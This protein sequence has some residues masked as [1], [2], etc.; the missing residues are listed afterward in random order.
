MRH[1]RKRNSH[2]VGIGRQNDAT[3]TAAKII[4]DEGIDKE[5][6]EAFTIAAANGQDDARTDVLNTIWDRNQGA[7]EA[8][9]VHEFV[10]ATGEGFIKPDNN[11]ETMYFVLK[12]GKLALEDVTYTQQYV[13][14]PDAADYYAIIAG[15][16]IAVR[17]NAL[18]LEFAADGTVV[19]YSGSYTA[20]GTY[21]FNPL[22]RTGTI[23]LEETENYSF[24][25]TEDTLY[26]GDFPYMRADA[27][28]IPASDS[29][30]LLGIWYDEA[31]QAGMLYFDENGVVIME[32]HGVVYDGTY[33][34]NKAAG[35]GT[36]VLQV[37]G[38]DVRIGLYLLYG[39]LYTDGDIIY[40]QY[41]VEQAS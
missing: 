25:M 4:A 31:G 36:M 10:H 14:Q 38:G 40:T 27:V 16:W 17:D 13:E 6:I 39:R 34:F 20:S 8:D 23:V 5:T 35:S 9:L 30:S 29:D 37:D 24:R 32:T 28:D 26:V 33:T 18:A 41:Y 7:C 12:D 21:T 2:D 1:S 3:T 15:S 22:D 19:F 11:G